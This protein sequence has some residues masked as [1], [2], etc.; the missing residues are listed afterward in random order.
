MHALTFLLTWEMVLHSGTAVE[1]GVLPA[2]AIAGA[3]TLGLL[4]VVVMSYLITLFFWSGWVFA[5]GSKTL[6]FFQALAIGSFA[7]AAIDLSHDALAFIFG[8]FDLASFVIFNPISR[9]IIVGS[10]VFLVGLKPK[11]FKN[12]WSPELLRARL[13]T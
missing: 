1:L 5:R 10:A 3:G 6:A 9:L 2:R 7:I 8:Y 13:F 4:L 12:D 11:F